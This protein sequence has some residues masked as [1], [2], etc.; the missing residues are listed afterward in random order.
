VVAAGSTTQHDGLAA[1]AARA[2]KHVFV[3]KPLA[4]TGAEAMRIYTAVQESGVIFQTGHFMR[5]DRLHR[6]IKHEIDAGNFG[7][8]TRARHSNT[9]SAALGG[10]FEGG[11]EWFYHKDKAGGGGFYDL[12]CHS[13]D[14]LV[15]FF[16]L[17]ESVT[18]AIAPKTVTYSQIDE[19]GEGILKFKNGVLA[20]V[21]GSWVDAGNPVTCE[22]RGT[23][24]HLTVMNG[25]AFYGSSKSKVPG[26]DGKQPLDAAH[27]PAGLP[28]AFDLYLDVLVGKAER[29]VLVPIEDALNVAKA[30]EA[31]YL[32]DRLG[33]WV[34]V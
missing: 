28:H 14:L 13:A 2:G 29:Q 16:G 34:K 18:A 10:W 3:E 11:Y 23:E 19:Y 20:A 26:A 5:S 32:G 4:T 21:T 6:F 1:A 31:M 27:F 25:Q 9:H 30:M 7:T 8:I 12:G 15:Y 17:I 24:G 33:Q 22:I